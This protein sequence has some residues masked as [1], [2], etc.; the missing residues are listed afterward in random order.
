MSDMQEAIEAARRYAKHHG[1]FWRSRLADHWANERLNPP[2]NDAD[3]P[4]LRQLRNHPA[5][6]LTW[7]RRFKP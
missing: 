4:L 3:A 2:K 6:N 1:R 5:Y 7:L